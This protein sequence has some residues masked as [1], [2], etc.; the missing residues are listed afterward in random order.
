ME[1]GALSGD[2]DV[3]CPY[4][5]IFSQTIGNH[6]RR[7]LLGKISRSLIIRIQDGIFA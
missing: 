7:C 5:R 2:R 3:A 1:R 6:F 4:I